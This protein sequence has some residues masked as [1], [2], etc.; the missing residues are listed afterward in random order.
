MITK[1]IVNLHPHAGDRSPSPL[2][3]EG[4]TLP[5]SR[6]PEGDR[7]TKPERAQGLESARE[8]IHTRRG[9]QV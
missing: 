6:A 9:R 2:G 4:V 8:G 7:L 3:G 1:V 5:L